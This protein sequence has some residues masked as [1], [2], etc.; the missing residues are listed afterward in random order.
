MR[1][2]AQSYLLDFYGS[3]GFESVGEPYPLDGI[4]HQDMVWGKGNGPSMGVTG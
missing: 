1:L 2:H 3:H 4:P